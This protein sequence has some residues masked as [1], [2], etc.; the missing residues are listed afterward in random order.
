[1]ARVACTDRNVLIVAAKGHCETF[2]TITLE[3]KLLLAQQGGFRFSFFAET[4][5]VKKKVSTQS[6][7]QYSIVCNRVE[8]NDLVSMLY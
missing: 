5:A 3:F 6:K 4:V 2:L 1:M 7:D 8:V